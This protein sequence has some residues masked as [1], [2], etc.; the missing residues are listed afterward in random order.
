V[1]ID[2]PL[3]HIEIVQSRQRTHALAHVLVIARN[4]VE[5][6]EKFFRKKV[7]VRVKAHGHE[8]FSPF[9]G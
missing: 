3:A 7:G 4:L 1:A 9:D 2:D 5:P 6:V 8:Q